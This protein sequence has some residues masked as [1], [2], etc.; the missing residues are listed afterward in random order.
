VN[1]YAPNDAER[2]R[3]G[4][5]VRRYALRRRLAATVI[6]GAVVVALVVLGVAITPWLIGAA[7]VLAAAYAYDL[8]RVVARYDRRARGAGAT[9]RAALDA[10]ADPLAL[11]RTATVTDRLSATFGVHGVRPLVVADRAY[12]AALVPD[13]GG[14]LMVVTSAL[15]KDF[16]LIEVEGVVAHCMARARL[17][18]LERECVAALDLSGEAARAL[19][20]PG[21]VYR[22]DEVAAAAI[23]YPLGIAA[24]LRRCR[25]AGV[26]SG[27][28]VDSEVFDQWRWVFF[29]P[30]SD[31]AASDLGDLDDPEVRARALEEW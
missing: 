17:G 4:A 19:A 11:E 25:G 26:P 23:R 15:V 6:M 30:W 8:R 28:F 13:A 16:D 9:L 31:R 18:L 2:H 27:S 1:P 24:A 10:D 3:H 12:N 29:N 22:A 21:E 20:G 14:Y 7:I 5:V